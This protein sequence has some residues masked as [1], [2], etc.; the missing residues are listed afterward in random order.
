MIS[1]GVFNR[2][3]ETRLVS[4]HFR[5]HFNGTTPHNHLRG[6]HTMSFSGG[7]SC[8]AISY[9]ITAEP[10]RGFQCQCRDCQRDTGGGH[11]SVF[12][13]PRS[14]VEL[15]GEVR[16]ISRTSDGGATKRKGFCANCG[17]PIYNKPDEKP[18]FIGIYVGSLDD[19]TAFRPA[20]ILY[21]SRGYAWDFLD[22]DVPKLAEWHP[23]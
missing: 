8:R 6:G 23:K 20:V 21:S 18:E 11:S 7:C 15:T 19:A 1:Y 16:E 10:V 3:R 17:V 2:I 9:T 4:R 14:A 5:H 22:P 13:F 12:V